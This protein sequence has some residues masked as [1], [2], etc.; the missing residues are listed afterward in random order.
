MST[1]AE[2]VATLKAEYP[3]LRV[4]DDERGYE[5]LSPTDYE[6]TIAGW[7]DNQLA[8]EAKAE[9]IIQ[10]A[11]DKAALLTK[12]GITADEAKLLVS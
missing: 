8:N 3:T 5:D 4:G 12:L 11:T 1:K 2:T 10:A 6:A 9:A 7:A